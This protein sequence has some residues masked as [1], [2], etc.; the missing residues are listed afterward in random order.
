MTEKNTSLALWFD[1]SLAKILSEKILQNYSE[2]N[3]KKFENSVKKNC[4]WKTLTQRVELICD[5]LYE[6]LP[7]D[8]EKSI[9]ILQ[10]NASILYD[11]L[12]FQKYKNK[13]SKRVPFVAQWKQIWL[14]SMKM[15]VWSLALLRRLRIQHCHELWCR[16]QTRL[17]SGIAV[18]VA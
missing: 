14:A 12:F 2:F 10:K 1:E 16:S 18:A 8:Y 17:R 4:D 7:K 3:S 11:G 5:F 9:E 15:Q 6:F 13:L